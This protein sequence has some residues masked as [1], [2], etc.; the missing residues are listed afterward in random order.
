M[1]PMSRAASPGARAGALRLRGWSAGV[2]LALVLAGVV[3]A[4]VRQAADA[5]V[6]A[7]GAA[8]FDGRAA[9]V[10]RIGG[11]ADPLPAAVVACTNCHVP[12]PQPAGVALSAD[13]LVA[14]GGQAATGATGS[15]AAALAGPG[16]RLHRDLLLDPV[17]RRGGP[18]SRYDR[19]AFCRTLQ[20]GEDPAGI[21]L[22]RVMPRYEIDAPTCTALW[23]FVTR[24]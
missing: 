23:R 5:R 9:L 17:A 22:P 12:R 18:P 4:A 13:A 6:L 3:V 16:P 11:H 14:G 10:A 8:L 24:S 19:A 7:G 2:V 1:R 15:G 20:S 21:L